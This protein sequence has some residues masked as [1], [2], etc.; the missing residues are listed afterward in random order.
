MQ[1]LALP[2]TD[3]EDDDVVKTICADP[4]WSEFEDDW[5]KAY[6]SYRKSGGNPWSVE[7]GD[8]DDVVRLKMYNLYTSKRKSTAL[9]KMR[10]MDLSSC[11][12]CGSLTT[13]ALDH[14]LP[15][16]EFQEF[17]LLRVN[18]VPACTHCNSSTKG[19]TVKGDEPERFLHPYYDEWVGEPLWKVLIE[20]SYE[21][22]TFGAAP[23]PGL[24][25]ERTCLVKFHL[26]NVLGKQF[27]RSMRT[28]W[29]T[30]PR[31]LAVS[32]KAYDT[33]SV[34]GAVTVDCERAMASHGC[35][36]W[37]AAFYRGVLA[38]TDAVEHIRMKIEE[39]IKDNAEV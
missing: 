9:S 7:P 11:P 14:H 25:E 2:A 27:K 38:N 10:D 24:G 37:H 20:P 4:E 31:S 15:R 39:L 22:A 26:K 19:S 1:N 13:G 30:Y 5:L 18:L 8:F 33:A 16:E 28:L 21:A 12:M 32:L 35:N 36:C 3:A 17:S 34:T 6:A 23:L 29:S